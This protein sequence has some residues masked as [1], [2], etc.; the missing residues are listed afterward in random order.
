MT[1]HAP[2]LAWRGAL[3]GL[4]HMPNLTG[5]RQARIVAAQ[6]EIESKFS[7]QFINLERQA[8]KPGAFNS[9]STWG[10]PGVN[11]HRHTVYMALASRKHALA[12]PFSAALRI[13]LIVRRLLRVTPH[14]RALKIST[15]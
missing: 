4:P 3:G 14:P 9:G 10:Q 12:T 2:S 8:L 6:V 15:V 5:A 13:H 7:K 11:L 1:L